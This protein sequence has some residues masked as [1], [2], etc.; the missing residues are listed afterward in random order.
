MRDYKMLAYQADNPSDRQSIIDHLD[1][2]L[3]SLWHGEYQTKT[4]SPANV[5]TVTFGDESRRRHFVR[6]MFDHTS[7]HPKLMTLSAA[8]L[9]QHTH[10]RVVAVWGLSRSEPGRTRDTARMKG[11]LQGVWSAQYGGDDRGHFFA[12]TMGG[13]LDINLFPQVR[14]VNR[15]GLWREMETYCAQNPGTFCFIR[16]IYADRTWRPA[17]LEYGIFKLPPQHALAFWGAEFGN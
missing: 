9:K 6:Y 13:G 16:P 7:G 2:A 15:W 10:D 14:T 12:H 11:F 1:T 5:L 17:R 8:A 4:R 3:P